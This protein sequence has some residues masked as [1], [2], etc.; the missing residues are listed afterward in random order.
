MIIIKIQLDTDKKTLKIEEA[1]KL[2]KLM[3]I[4]KRLLPNGEW[5]DF[6]LLTNTTIEHW[7][8]P[9]VFK[10][11]WP[12]PVHPWWQQP[13]YGQTVT[14]YNYSTHSLTD[15]DKYLCSN[16]GATG[17]NGFGG[18]GGETSLSMKS[19]NMVCELKAGTYNIEV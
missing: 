19:E 16:T 12:T 4:V 10:E 7:N 14:G 3:A 18:G 8:A 17:G 1:V 2:T 9:I 15:P 11:F 6:T 5:Q 13:W